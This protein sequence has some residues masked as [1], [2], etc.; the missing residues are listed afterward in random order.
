MAASLIPSLDGGRGRLHGRVQR[1]R[2][3]LRGGRRLPVRLT[4][5]PRWLL[6]LVTHQAGGGGAGGDERSQ[7]PRGSPGQDEELAKRGEA[8]GHGQA[9]VTKAA[10]EAEQGA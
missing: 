7:G 6:A 4:R 1:R 8:C 9:A 5:R 2:M 3:R 10:Q